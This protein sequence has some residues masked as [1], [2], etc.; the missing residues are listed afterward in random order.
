M[1]NTNIMLI[2]IYIYLFVCVVRSI[3]HRGFYPEGTNF[4]PFFMHLKDIAYTYIRLTPLVNRL[5]WAVVYT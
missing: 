5:L 1:Y 3:K 4:L 2:H